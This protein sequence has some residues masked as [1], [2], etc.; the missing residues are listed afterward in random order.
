MHTTQRLLQNVDFYEN[1]M[2]KL[3]FGKVTMVLEWR[4]SEHEYM[5]R[6][7]MDDPITLN[8]LRRCDLLKF[9]H[10]S[11]MCAQVQLHETLVI[12]CDHDLV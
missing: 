6:L 5:D 12:L 7:A 4:E 10:T 11:N 2:V 1:L 9:Y 3:C 8:A